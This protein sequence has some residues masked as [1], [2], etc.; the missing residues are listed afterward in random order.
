MKIAYFDCP[1]GLSGNMILGALIDAG[2]PL[3]YLKREL[4]KIPIRGYEIVC[5]MM[6]KH[7][8]LAQHL[9]VEIDD[10]HTSRTIDDIYS[11]IKRSKLK[12]S[13]KAL[14]IKI[15]R[16]LYEA[17]TKV[18]GRHKVHLHE[19]GAIDAIVDVMGAS[20]GFDKL[21][22]KEVYCSPLPFGFGPIHHA[23]GLLPNP[24]PA[25][26]VI[27]KGSPIYRRNIK[28]E[29]VTPTG[30]AIISTIVKSFSDMPKLE[31]K[32][33]GLGAGTSDFHEPNVLRLFIGE[34]KVSYK[35][36]LIL[37]IETNIDNMNPE[38]YGYVIE[39]LM[40]AGALDAYTTNIKMKK[41]RPGIML[42]ALCRIEDKEKI[43]ETIFNE[44]S[45]LGI[46]TYVIKREKL[47]R[48]IRTIKTRY[49]KIAVKIGKMNGKIKNV[50]PEYEDCLKISKKNNVPLKSVYDEVRSEA[51][52]LFPVTLP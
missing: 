7:G 4:K 16:K 30:A 8:V 12:P 29:L 19:V 14:G 50:A 20:I 38:L 9:D 42:T 41:G 49:G 25:T 40:K 22:I 2:L 26:A 51:L 17:E 28:G 37:S 48:E 36:D 46:R 13:I 52:K 31:L 15:F 6:N 34:S 43:E 39:K 47:D 5:K 44:T 1:T 23:H 3:P 35:D 18:H 33:L 21:G 27:M 32:S 10:I 45:T 24:A 11:V